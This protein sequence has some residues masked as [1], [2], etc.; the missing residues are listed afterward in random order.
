MRGSKLQRNTIGNQRRD[1]RQAG[2]PTTPFLF[3]PENL[4]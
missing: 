3:T 2:L 4:Y 1:I